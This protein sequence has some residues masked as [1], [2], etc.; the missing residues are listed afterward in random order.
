MTPCFVVVGFPR[1]RPEAS[2]LPLIFATPGD[3]YILYNDW[4]CL[5]ETRFFLWF[6]ETLLP[7]VFHVHGVFEQKALKM[8]V[9]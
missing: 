2:A 6:K 7:R 1:G 5:F 4:R 8:L 9:M 3:F